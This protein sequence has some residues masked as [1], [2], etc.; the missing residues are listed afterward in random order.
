MTDFKLAYEQELRRAQ[1]LKSRV[2][3]LEEA[4][5]I[6]KKSSLDASAGKQGLVDRA[7][8]LDKELDSALKELFQHKHRE[9]QRKQAGAQVS[10]EI[11]SLKQQ[12]ADLKARVDPLNEG[13]K[14]KDAEIS[15]LNAAVQA[16]ENLNRELGLALQQAQCR[17]A[18]PSSDAGPQGNP[19]P[20]TGPAGIQGPPLQADRADAKPGRMALPG[21]AAMAAMA[22][23][24]QAKGMPLPSAPERP[25]A[26]MPP[27]RGER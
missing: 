19:E 22:A 8:R 10:E 12:A 3:E 16:L 15:K 20:L 24:R 26:F 13:C 5:K 18:A 14:A 27:H 6:E 11:K 17:V 1:D 9:K 7:A 21:L 25:T 2:A 23:V 4:L